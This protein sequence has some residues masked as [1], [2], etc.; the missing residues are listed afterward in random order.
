MTISLER[1]P[2]LAGGRAIGSVADPACGQD[3]AAVV[4]VVYQSALRVARRQSAAVASYAEDIA[5]EV[6]LAFLETT[7][8][9]TSP[10]GWAATR[11]RFVSTNVANRKVRRAAELIWLDEGDGIDIWSRDPNHDPYR[12]VAGAEAYARVRSV[13][14][15]REQ[16]VLRLVAEGYSHDEIAQELGYASNRVVTTT[17]SRARKKVL[18]AFT[19]E[20]RRELFDLVVCCLSESIEP[21]PLAANPPEPR[22]PDAM[23]DQLVQRFR[24]ELILE[25]IAKGER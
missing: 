24:G 22:L 19:Q 1:E 12:V 7:E 4:E 15:D 8:E 11:A 3:V 9:V 5:M 23:I 17:V 21:E 25:R 14:S 2:A 20:Q 6:V 18:D 13:L 10:A 16:E